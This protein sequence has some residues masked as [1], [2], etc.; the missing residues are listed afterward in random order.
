MG[1]LLC[2]LFVFSV[3]ET[4]LAAGCESPVSLTDTTPYTQNFDGLASTGTTNI[5]IL[6]G[7]CLNEVGTSALVNGQYSAG[8]GIGSSGDIYSFGTTGRNERALGSR[9]SSSITP[10]FGVSFLNNTGRV[11]TGFQ[12]SYRGE[13][14]S[15]GATGSTDR[16]DFQYSLDA[17]NL[18]TGGWTQS[19]SLDFVTLDTVM[20]GSKDGNAATILLNGMITDLN[21]PDGGEFSIRWLD[22]N[23]MASDDGLAVDDFS[24]TPITGETDITP[25]AL[26][27]TEA[28]VT[29]TE[30]TVTPTD[31]VV[32]S[33]RIRDIQGTSHLSPL[34]GAIEVGVQNIP[35]IVTAKRSNGFYI[36]DPDLSS[37]TSGVASSEAIFVFTGTSPAGIAIRDSVNVGDPVLISGTLTEFRPGFP[38]N[39][40]PCNVRTMADMALCSG[41]GLSV[42]EIVSRNAQ[43]LVVT[44][45]ACTGTCTITPTI[46]GTSGRIPPAVTL[47][48]ESANIETGG[49]FNAVTDGIDFYESLEGM[50]VTLNAGVRVV[51]PSAS[52]T[53]GTEVWVV[54]DNFANS[55]NT[56]N[57]RGGLTIAEADYHNPERIRIS[58][59]TG[60]AAM[61]AALPNLNVGASIDSAVEGIVDYSFNNFEVISL[62]TSYAVT[63]SPLTKEVTSLVRNGPLQL[64]I[65]TFNVENLGGNASAAVWFIHTFGD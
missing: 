20:V 59:K 28:T 47:N 49:T 57:P 8:S 2:A 19:D 9:L 39:P 42:T 12:V 56:P 54:T 24:L 13:Q 60:T 3:S 58:T 5:L 44:P 36:Q 32:G 7:W 40:A 6:S 25:V 27:P 30:A 45:W 65:A 63:Q 10:S 37:D 16:L 55:N 46:M 29:P 15:L 43:A 48:T 33:I 23:S 53:S 11:I 38:P 18:S 17:T 31:D 51:G 50:R 26:T 62:S 34:I 61:G 21:I 4:A 35:G 52:F 14:W 1:Y 22:I 64:T 41:P